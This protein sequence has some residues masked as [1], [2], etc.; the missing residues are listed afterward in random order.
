MLKK[1]YISKQTVQLFFGIILSVFVLTQSVQVATITTDIE[2]QT[3]QSESEKEAEASVVQSQAITNSTSQI[4]LGFDSYLL[5]EVTFQ[6]E[7]SRRKISSELLI[8]TVH[9]AIWVLLRKIISPNA[10]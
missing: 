5:D 3:D 2:K 7:E 8:P 9:K 6:E 10:P 1:T 4:S